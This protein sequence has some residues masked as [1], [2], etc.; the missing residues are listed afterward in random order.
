MFI[1][2]LNT[3]FKLFVVEFN[4]YGIFQQISTKVSVASMIKIKV[5]LL[6][7]RLIFRPSPST[8]RFEYEYFLRSKFSSTSTQK[9][10]A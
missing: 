5:G 7:T 1:I 2:S 10:C 9:A 4:F 6:C 8:F 3:G